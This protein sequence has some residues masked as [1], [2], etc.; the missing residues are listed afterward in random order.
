MTALYVDDDFSDTYVQNEGVRIVCGRGSCLCLQDVG[1]ED[2]AY[3]V[4]K[5][6]WESNKRA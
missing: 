4:L 6:Y 1:D 3:Q 5:D 2:M